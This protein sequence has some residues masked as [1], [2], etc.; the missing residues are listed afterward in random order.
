MLW[1]VASYVI[2]F[3]VH[4]LFVCVCVLLCF[5]KPI[6]GNRYARS[7]GYMVSEPRETHPRSEC[8][9][10]ELRVFEILIEVACIHCLLSVINFEIWSSFP[11][12]RASSSRCTACSNFSTIGWNSTDLERRSFSC[13]FL[14]AI[15]YGFLP[16]TEYTDHPDTRT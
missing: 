15:C 7:R 14:S 4:F 8:H 16:V 11:H 9:R 12:F 6:L 1:Q 13:L 5:I 3:P 10:Q 2:E